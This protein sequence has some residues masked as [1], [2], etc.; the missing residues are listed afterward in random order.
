MARTSSVGYNPHHTFKLTSLLSFFVFCVLTEVLGKQ[1]VYNSFVWHRLTCF[2]YFLW[3][4]TSINSDL[5][6]DNLLSFAA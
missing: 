2:N 5:V 3:S 4:L 6:T 1:E